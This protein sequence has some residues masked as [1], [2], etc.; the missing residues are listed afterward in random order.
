MSEDKKLLFVICNEGGT[1]N[2]TLVC[3]PVMIE[4][5]KYCCHERVTLGETKYN[6]LLVS[7]SAMTE[8]EINCVQ[9]HKECRKPI[10]N[11]TVIARLKAK[12][13]RTESPISSGRGP[14]HPSTTP[15]SVRPKRFRTIAKEQICLFSSCDF[16]GMGATL[17]QI[18]H[19]TLDDQVRLLIYN[20]YIFFNHVLYNTYDNCSISG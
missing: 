6:E 3:N 15:G 7:L 2:K 19:K 14:G 1:K 12:R 17:L 4:D 16:C 10:V 20:I 8:K 5:L 9:Y 18:K 13:L 11:K